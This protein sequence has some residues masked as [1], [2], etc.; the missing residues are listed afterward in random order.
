MFN[1]CLSFSIK[2][3]LIKLR[4]KLISNKLLELA[5]KKNVN[6]NKS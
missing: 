2:I 5:Y 6:K 1:K 4:G 3:I